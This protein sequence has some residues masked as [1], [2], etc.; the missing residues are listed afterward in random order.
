[1]SELLHQNHCSQS[2]HDDIQ[3]VYEIIE[4]AEGA[5]IPITECLNAYSDQL[6]LEK[7]PKKP[8]SAFSKS[9]D[10]DTEVKCRFLLA[11]HCIE[12]HGL[13]RIGG[14][15]RNA[16]VIHCQMFNWLREDD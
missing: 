2:L 3:V 5:K 13:I 8:R 16:V 4:A 14:S 10:P 7:R 9:L 15:K 12:R 1:M 6:G 11:L